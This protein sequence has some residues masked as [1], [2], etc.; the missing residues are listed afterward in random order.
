MTVITNK[1]FLVARLR[2]VAGVFFSIACF[3]QSIS[4]YVLPGPQILELMT[5][6]SRPAKT[7]L[8]SQ[9]LLVHEDSMQLAPVEFNE[10]L[11]YAFPD[12]FRSDIASEN[13]QRIYV[14]SS[15]SAVTVIDGKISPQP[16]TLFDRYKDIILYHS[17]VRLNEQLTL[18]G[19]DVTI[20]SVGRFEGR[21]AYVLGA[22]YPDESNS[23]I[24][25][26]RQTFRPF[27]WLLVAGTGGG[28]TDVLDVR[29]ADW[30]EVR[31]LWYPMQIAFYQNQRLVREIQVTHVKVNPSFSRKIFDIQH[32]R[33]IYQPMPEIVPE[34][35]EAEGIPEI[36][37][38]IEDFKRMYE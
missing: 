34:K 22:Q 23:Q 9:K 16:E 20:T 10:T 17:R 24:W 35:K 29:Y 19:V 37:K 27:R 30:Q 25:F 14:A 38:T 26:D 31:G 18:L 8:V 36:Q 7:L 33:S 5:A 28:V 4:A 12:S 15:G 13:T 3:S 21:I 11:K 6:K 2:V 32:L 1:R